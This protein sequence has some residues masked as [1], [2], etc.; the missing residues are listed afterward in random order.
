MAPFMACPATRPVADSSGACV[1]LIDPGRGPEGH[2]KPSGR[3]ER[4][5][6][7]GDLAHNSDNW[8]PKNLFS[9]P[10][11]DFTEKGDYRDALDLSERERYVAYVIGGLIGCGTT[12]IVVPSPLA[13]F[14][15]GILLLSVGVFLQIQ[16]EMRCLG[17]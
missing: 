10:T 15:F 2:A 6:L 17:P 14:L 13:P 4:V 7:D 12:L 9:S 1:L 5:I 3:H 16:H 11:P 8:D